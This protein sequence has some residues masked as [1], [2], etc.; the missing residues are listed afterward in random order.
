MEIRSLENE[1][2]NLLLLQDLLPPNTEENKT[3]IHKAISQTVLSTAQLANLLPTG[4]VLA[5]Q[6]LAPIFSNQGRCDLVSGLMTAGLVFLCGLSC[7]LSSFTDSFRDKKGNV[8]NGFAT[9]NGFWIFD[10]S[11]TLPPELAAYYKLRCLDF[12]H[13]IMSA[14][15]FAAIVLVD[16]NIMNCFCPSPTVERRE[17]LTK[18]PVSIGVISSMLFVAF[19]TK[20]HG[21]GFPLTRLLSATAA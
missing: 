9:I 19:P 14:L 18:L 12:M 17:I 16:Q 7:F 13:A 8:C 20:R 10:A 3:Q 5:F 11:A 4:T 2:E 21:I 6:L 15:V 1:N